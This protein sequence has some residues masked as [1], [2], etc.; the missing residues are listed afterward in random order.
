MGFCGRQHNLGSTPSPRT[1]R[2][3]RYDPPTSCAQVERI[4]T[5]AGDLKTTPA[6]TNHRHLHNPSA[7]IS[8]RGGLAT[9][10]ALQ[11]IA[12]SHAWILPCYRPTHLSA[13]RFPLS[14]SDLF[15][16]ISMTAPHQG[17]AFPLRATE[18]QRV[19]FFLTARARG[20]TRRKRERRRTPWATGLI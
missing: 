16:I 8:E 13:D 4:T 9:P 10:R 11:H 19:L 7:I 12:N 18:R 15:C 5:A 6:P 3:L 14:R 1:P 20:C 17:G 2:T